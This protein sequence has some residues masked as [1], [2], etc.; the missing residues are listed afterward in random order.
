MVTRARDNDRR[1]NGRTRQLR[2]AASG[3]TR[4]G[5]RVQ[6]RR[7]VP[8]STGIALVAIGAVL[9][10]SAWY[11]AWARVEWDAAW[12]PLHTPWAYMF[13]PIWLG[14]ILVLDGFNVLRSGTSPLTRGPARFAVMFLA[15]VAFWWVFEALNSS[16]NN[17]HYKLDQPYSALR[18]NAMASLCFST[19]L[20]AVM[21][22][23]ELTA[24][25]PWLRPI[26]RYDKPGPRLPQ[27]A[28]FAL[29]GVGVVM[30]VLPFLFPRY[31]FPLVWLSLIFILD[32]LANLAGRKSAFAHL[33][34]RD[35]QWI[36][37][38]ALAGICCG[39]CWE[40]WNSLSLPKWSYTVPFVD[41]A[42]HLF[43]MPL[44]GYLGYLPFAVELFAMYQVFLVLIR[45]RDDNL[46]V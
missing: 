43:E 1:A 23:A 2:K 40:M 16:V 21:E 12:L 17:W 44:P 19:V 29:I 24:S 9:N 11:C 3:A 31:T 14:F 38:I 33:L 4:V 34:A 5:V 22:M 37:A 45:Q 36:V 18:Y 7:T 13:F 25:I 30:F 27:R 15:S 20:P 35:W 32:P 28:A 26:L 41:A 39:F 6:N 8:Q 46:R 42:P 10:I